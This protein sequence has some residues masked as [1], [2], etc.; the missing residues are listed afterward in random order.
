MPWP[1]DSRVAVWRTRR[2]MTGMVV[3]YI[4]RPDYLHDEEVWVYRNG[5]MI[6]TPTRIDWDTRLEDWEKLL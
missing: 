6:S 3:K 2:K 4:L 5:E 1:R